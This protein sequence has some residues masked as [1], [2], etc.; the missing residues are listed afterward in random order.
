MH[1]EMSEPDQR[2]KGSKRIRFGAYWTSAALAT[3]VFLMFIYVMSMVPGVPP[4]QKLW[5]LS[6]AGGLLVASLGIG[7]W[8]F[9]TTE[10]PIMAWPLGTV[11]GVALSLELAECVI[12]V[13]QVCSATPFR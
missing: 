7:V 8:K 9:R 12:G 5:M 2:E 11:V 13:F 6:V 10:A 1:T 4:G 3:I